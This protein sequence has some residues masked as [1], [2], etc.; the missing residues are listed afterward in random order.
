MIFRNFK[1]RKIVVCACIL[2]IFFPACG[3]LKGEFAFRGFGE[4]AYRKI[5]GIPE[6][7]KSGRIEW[8][9][10]FKKV[11]EAQKI[12]VVFLKKELVWVDINT[13]ME[14]IDKDRKIIY[15]GFENLDEGTY[16]ILISDG[17]DAVSEKEFIIFY[18]EEREFR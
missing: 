13:R 6:F 10:V 7:E 15:G 4:E 2:F 11:K 9:F 14:T 1:A 12:G 8:V 3:R 5:D 16:K 18:D 17:Q